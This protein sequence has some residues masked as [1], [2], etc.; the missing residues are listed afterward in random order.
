VSLPQVDGG[1]KPGI[2][3]CFVVDGY[4]PLTPESDPKAAARF[5]ATLKDPVSGRAMDVVG[6]QPGVQ[7]RK[8]EGGGKSK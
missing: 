5:F 8:N 7:V 6:T 3:H 4:T 1:G 2:D